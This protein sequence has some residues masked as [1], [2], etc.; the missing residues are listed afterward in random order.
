MADQ[1]TTATAGVLGGLPALPRKP[2]NNSVIAAEQAY[3]NSKNLPLLSEEDMEA[4][5]QGVPM[6]WEAG[7]TPVAAASSAPTAATAPAQPAQSVTASTAVSSNGMSGTAGGLPPLPRKPLN[8]SVISAEQAY[9]KRKGIAA[10]SDAEVECLKQGLP[11]PCEP[12]GHMPSMP[13]NVA[14][15]ESAS[16]GAAQAA[17]QAPAAAPVP[18]PTSPISNTAGG[19]PPLPRKAPNNS[20]ISAEQAY[21]KKKGIPQLNEVEVECLKQGLP[22]P[23]EPGG[24]MPTLSGAAAPAATPAATAA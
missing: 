23:W 6:P 21:R 22:M 14:P 16:G 15:A 11:M 12:G 18:T 1:P 3:R 13:A 7:G 20:V 19:L 5:R 24:K 9:R 10:L 8:N 17:M 2:L 4:L